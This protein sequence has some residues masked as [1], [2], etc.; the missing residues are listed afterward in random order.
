VNFSCPLPLV[1]QGCRAV[2]HDLFVRG[3]GPRLAVRDYG[4]SGPPILL[5]HG[6]YGNLASFDYLGPLLTSGLRVVAY[7]QRGHGWSE[8]GRIGIAEFR[9]DLAAVVGALAPAFQ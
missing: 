1:V 5:I 2:S 3:D 7:D 4:G 8:P 9:A 6:H